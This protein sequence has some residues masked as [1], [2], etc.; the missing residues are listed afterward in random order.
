MNLY[1]ENAYSFYL[2]RPIRKN[3]KNL[4]NKYFHISGKWYCDGCKKYHS[5]RIIAY[6]PCDVCD[7]ICLKHVE[8]QEVS[9]YESVFLGK[10]NI[11]T[12]I[13]REFAQKSNGENDV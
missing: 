5:R 8:A 6:Y 7:G 10:T 12:V 3:I 1:K 4:K 9:K 11:T 2:V 13:K